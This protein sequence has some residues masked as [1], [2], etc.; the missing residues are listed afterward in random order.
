MK[1]DFSLS[2]SD[3]MA[4]FEEFFAI[5][6]NFFSKLGIQLFADSNADT[7]VDADTEDIVKF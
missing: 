4:L 5:I 1:I 3:Y 2:I 7:D 6:T